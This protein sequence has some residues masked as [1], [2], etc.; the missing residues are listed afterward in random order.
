MASS[1]KLGGGQPVTNSH[2]AAAAGTGP[3]H[4]VVRGGLGRPRDRRH[5]QVLPAEWQQAG[6]VAVGE[7]TE[8]S[9]AHET[10]R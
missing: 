6:T 7:E 1:G 4:V 5:R 10:S 2:E 9:D 3:G 8:V